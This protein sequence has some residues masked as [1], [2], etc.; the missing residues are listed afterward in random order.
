MENPWRILFLIYLLI[1]SLYSFDDPRNKTFFGSSLG[2]GS[3]FIVPQLI[4]SG[5]ISSGK[6]RINT[7]F[8]TDIKIGY[9]VSNP[10][11]II[12]YCDNDW[13]AP[14]ST[15]IILNKYLLGCR[16]YP[17]SLR[18]S[19]FLEA[20]LGYGFWFYPFDPTWNKYYSG[21]GFCFSS[22]C[23]YRLAK[24]LSVI[25]EYQQFRPAYDNSINSYINFLQ[26]NMTK[27]CRLT[28]EYTLQ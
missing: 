14:Y 10:L 12:F 16:Y 23:G 11:S 24:R 20:A 28:L 8:L 17:E 6:L 3:E 22:G 13:I 1:S 15:I 25:I 5:Q 21:G 4:I 19:L 7:S 18:Q 9:K 2:V 27:S 26:L